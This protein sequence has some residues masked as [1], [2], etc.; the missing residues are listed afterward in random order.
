MKEK[1]KVITRK[2]KYTAENSKKAVKADSKI[3]A[4]EAKDCVVYACANA[5][6]MDYDTSHA[7]VKE[8]F[9]RKEKKGTR[10]ALLLSGF[11]KMV[12][13][14]EVVNG[15][16]VTDFIDRPRN[17]YKCYGEVV[18]RLNRVYSFAEQNKEGTYVI[19]VRNHALV[20]KDG[21]IV[22]SNQKV[23]AKALVQHAYKVENA[24]EQ[25]EG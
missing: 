12:D 9:H 14:K 7:F 25:K 21:V 5:F 20:V 18:Q 2:V 24:P 23:A 6:G 15:K 4:K 19:L 10:T 13:D 1:Q 3:A 11:N 16:V 8:R 22:D 17:A